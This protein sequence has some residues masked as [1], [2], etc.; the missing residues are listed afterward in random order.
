MSED[1]KPTD[2]DELDSL[3]QTDGDASED[4]SDALSDV[5]EVIEDS[6]D[7]DE[8]TEDQKALAL[9]A[10]NQVSGKNFTS[11]E[12]AAKSLHHA[13]VLAA[14]KGKQKAAEKKEVAKETP[15][16]S[17]ETQEIIEELLVTRHPEANYV[18]SDDKL[19]KELETIAKANGTSIL[20]VY[21]NSRY[22]QG[23]AKALADAAKEEE[24]NKSKVSKPASGID[25]KVRLEDVK[26]SDV[27][28]LTPAQKVKWIQMQAKKER[29]RQD[30]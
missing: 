17:Q 3:N 14:E 21:R 20:K 22:F 12:K 13:E 19:R 7:E 29:L 25:N 28:K 4:T 16:L 23:E 2:G 5:L 10:L 27:S 24:Q 8:L 18:L 11:L 1:I 26:D 15:T 9:K 6:G 30:D